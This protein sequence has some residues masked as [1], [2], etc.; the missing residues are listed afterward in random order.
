MA[1]VLA[2]VGFL[3]TVCLAR[4][5]VAT[6]SKRGGTD[7]IHDLIVALFVLS[8]GIFC[9]AAGM[10]VLRLPYLRIE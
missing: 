1:V 4:L 9:F 3:A 5:H 7:M 6:A 8:G 10:G 2:L